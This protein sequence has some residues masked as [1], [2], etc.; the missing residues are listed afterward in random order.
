M[1]QNIFLRAW[2]QGK[3]GGAT[4]L[5]LLALADLADDWGYCYPSIAALARKS[6]QNK[7]IVLEMLTK[8]ERMGDIRRLS[9]ERVKLNGRTTTHALIQVTCGMS[10]DHIAFSEKASPLYRR[11]MGQVELQK[12]G[13]EEIIV[14]IYQPSAQSGSSHSSIGVAKK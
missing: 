2:K 9:L 10:P 11:V 7:K 12:G 13:K 14:S 3:A 6:R 1:S 8:L 5:V 4:L